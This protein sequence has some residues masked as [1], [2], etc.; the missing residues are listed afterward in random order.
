MP[1]G[2]RAGRNR[3]EEFCNHFFVVVMRTIYNIYGFS[4]LIH[5]PFEHTSGNSLVTHVRDWLSDY[6]TPRLLNS[7]LTL[8]PL[9]LP[10]FVLL[11]ILK[12]KSL[13]PLIPRTP[14]YF[15]SPLPPFWLPLSPYPVQVFGFFGFFSNARI[16]LPPW[17]SS[18]PR[19]PSSRGQESPPIHFY[20][21]FP[22]L[23]HV[24][25]TPEEY[26]NWIHCEFI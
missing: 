21:Y 22:K 26:V 9:V 25:G 18:F 15:L 23:F 6:I 4:F 20:C 2:A 17:N 19:P 3:N 10:W 8:Q 12:K 5:L 13:W 1:E 16:S 11:P 7:R 24:A 14:F